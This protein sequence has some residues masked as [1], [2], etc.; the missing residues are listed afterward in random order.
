[1]IRVLHYVGIMNRGGMESFI[2]N[3]YR[4]INREKIQFDF[5]IHGN[6][7]GD[8]EKEITELGGKF[9]YFPHMRENPLKYRKAWRDFWKTNSKH[10]VAFHMH[11]NSLANVIAM[12]EAAKAKIPVRIIHAHSS[13]ADK[14]KLQWLNDFLHKN[15]QKRLPKLA[16]NLF[17]CSEAA[18]KWLFGETEIRDLKVL[19]IKNGI[20]I[21]QFKFDSTK[22]LEIRNKLGLA[23]KKVIGHA[24]TFLPVKNHAFLINVVEQAYRMDNSVRCVLLG[25]GRLFDEIKSLV[26]EKNLEKIV[27]FMGKRDD[28][29]DMLSAMDLFVMPSLFEGLPVSLVEV[30]TNGLPVLVSDGITSDVKLCNNFH[31][32]SLKESAST[33]AENALEIMNRNERNENNSQCV[34]AAGFDIKDT[35]RLYE[36]IIENGRKQIND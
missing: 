5:A 24:G 21:E 19:Q 3:L 1:M 27:L 32:L 17:S 33:W 12:E 6:S 13:M 18:T 28:V 4:S 25:D 8:Y 11:T 35:A 20:D 9:Y 7:A 15:H 23:D 30:Q 14:G 26:K 22:R 31:F 34:R 2:M 29:Q 10:Y 16:T 36:T